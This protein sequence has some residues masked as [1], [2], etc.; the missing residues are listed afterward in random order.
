MGIAHAARTAASGHR[1]GGKVF[2][3]LAAPLRCPN[4]QKLG[5]E[6]TSLQGGECH[7]DRLLLDPALQRGERAHRGQLGRLPPY[8]AGPSPR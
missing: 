7:G 5:I 3:T 6:W 8:R 1:L 4:Y 2:R